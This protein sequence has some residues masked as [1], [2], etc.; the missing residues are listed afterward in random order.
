MELLALTALR[1]VGWWSAPR[2]LTIPLP[3]DLRS[4]SVRK[5]WEVPPGTVYSFA[6]YIFRHLN[7]WPTNGEDDYPRNIRALSSHLTPACRVF[8]LDEAT[9]RRDST[10]QGYIQRRL[11]RHPGSER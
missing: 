6:F 11:D 1:A 2:D 9:R 7:R 3:P 5:W 8:L 4:G 10:G